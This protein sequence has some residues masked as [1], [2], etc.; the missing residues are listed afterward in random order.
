MSD[1]PR[2]Q[3]DGYR[4][5]EETH[6]EGGYV[7]PV[8]PRP[9][10]EERP[11]PQGSESRVE[12][13]PGRP[14]P[15]MAGEGF[16]RT[17]R[18][19]NKVIRAERGRGFWHLAIGT[20]FYVMVVGGMADYVEPGVRIGAHLV[21]WLLIGL[22]FWIAVARERRHDWGPRPR[23]PWA[24]AALGGAVAVELLI[25]TMG[26]PMIIVGSVILL[27]LGSFFLMLVG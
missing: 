13:V 26:S 7:P 19:R 8:E 2:Q 5:P 12:P 24:A 27:A 4:S 3:P 11:P 16:R 15:T 25:L 21:F 18:A 9:G 6:G 17:T 22:G 23:W 10:P 20:V 14:A 1:S